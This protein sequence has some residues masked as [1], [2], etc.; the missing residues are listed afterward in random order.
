MISY[1]KT[2]IVVSVIFIL[3]AI[4]NCRGNTNYSSNNNTNGDKNNV[5][6]KDLKQIINKGNNIYVVKT[7]IDLRG[8]TLSL[9]SNAILEFD[10]GQIRNGTLEGNNTKIIRQGICFDNIAIQGLW[11]VPEISTSMFADLSPVNSLQNLIALANPNIENHIVIEKG[12]YVVKSVKDDLECLKIPSNTEIELRGDIVLIPNNF[13]HY[14]V[15]RITGNNVKINGGGSIIGDKLNHYGKKG[16]W[17]MGIFVWDGRNVTISNIN[18]SDCWGDCIYIGGNSDNV[19]IDNCLLN[20]GRRQGISITSCGQVEIYN[21]QITNIKGT[22]PET[23]IDIE[24][25]AGK[26]V[27]DVIIRDVKLINCIGG[28]LA[29]GYENN[30]SI[31]NISVENCAIFGSRKIPLR[32]YGCKKVSVE[33]S[34]VLYKTG[35]DVVAKE[36]IGDYKQRNLITR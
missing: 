1:N 9:P 34:T 2:R 29:Y 24:P 14:Y 17:G 12:L 36:R 30:A 15:F 8:K 31:G 3:V 6:I 25:N 13:E 23:G 5:L 21:C 20:N 28:I 27:N 4:I 16:E 26:T 33:S 10:G 19:R 11:L 22:A 7:L 18:I 32:F 35:S